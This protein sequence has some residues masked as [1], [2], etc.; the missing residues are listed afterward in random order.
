MTSDSS[1]AN[2]TIT[3]RKRDRGDDVDVLGGNALHG[4]FAHAVPAEDLLGEHRPGDQS[5][6]P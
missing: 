5:A 2:R 4:P 3:R 1:P 6:M